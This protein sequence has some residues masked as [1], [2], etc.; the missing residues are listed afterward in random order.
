V[1]ELTKF[2]DREEIYK[3]ATPIHARGSLL[4]NRQLQNLGLEQKYE[5]IQDGEKVK[6]IYLKKPNRIRENVIAF[7]T[8]LPAEF[9]L[10]SSVDYDTMFNK[11]FLDPLEPI[12]DAVGWAAEPRATLED[13]FI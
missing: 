10:T 5:R 9:G 11:T 4:Y 8:V 2:S 7:P 6:F 1:S 12:L 13:F 3:K